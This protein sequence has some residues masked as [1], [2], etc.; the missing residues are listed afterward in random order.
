M[1]AFSSALEGGLDIVNVTIY[2]LQNNLEEALQG[3]KLPNVSTK[4]EVP[5]LE[6]K[7]CNSYSH[8]SYLAPAYTVVDIDLSK[9]NKEET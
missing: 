1:L 5:Y 2:L 6:N 8:P 9:K 7:T 3:C 4:V